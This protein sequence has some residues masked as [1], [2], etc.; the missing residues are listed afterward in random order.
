MKNVSCWRII[1]TNELTENL[2]GAALIYVNHRIKKKKKGQTYISQHPWWKGKHLLSF[3]S[4]FWK[5]F[6]SLNLILMKNERKNSVA[7]L[8]LILSKVQISVAFAS[9]FINVCVVF[10]F[11]SVCLSLS[12]W[13]V[14][15]GP[16]IRLLFL[17]NRALHSWVAQY[18][19]SHLSNCP[20]SSLVTISRLID[21]PFVAFFVPSFS[22]LCALLYV[23]QRGWVGGEEA[24][25]LCLPLCDRMPE[26][27]QVWCSHRSLLPPLSADD[28]F[29][30]AAAAAILH[31]C[32]LTSNDPIVLKMISEI[33]HFSFTIL[34]WPFTDSSSLPLI[35]HP[36]ISP[37]FSFKNIVCCGYLACNSRVTCIV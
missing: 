25:V 13:T 2:L 19:S 4:F 33:S 27:V 31:P 15:R 1:W 22:V 30:A 37:R 35:S 11:L 32:S 36:S 16:D 9:M 12:E 6:F 3:Q 10:Y 7:V 28:C 17:F 14:S 26:G 29:F 21:M 8:K 5:I 23:F 20:F 24:V 18:F 34:S